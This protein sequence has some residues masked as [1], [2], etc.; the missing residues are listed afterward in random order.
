M[1]K[2]KVVV[3]LIFYECLIDNTP[4]KE[5]R[6]KRSKAVLWSRSNLDRLRLRVMWP[7]PAPEKNFNTNL[8]KNYRFEK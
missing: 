1:L 5:K 8:N 7:A 4:C 3:S 6:Y 2:G